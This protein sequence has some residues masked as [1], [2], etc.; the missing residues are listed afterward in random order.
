MLKQKSIDARGLGSHYGSEP[1]R[2]GKSRGALLNIKPTRENSL[3]HGTSSQ[4]CYVGVNIGA[5]T[6]KAVALRGASV[7]SGVK[8]HQGRP[9]E[10]LEEMLASKEFS[11]ADYFGVSGHRGHISEAAAI[12]RVLGEISCDFDA[13][14][15]L[16]GESFLVY[17]LANGRIMN[18]LSHNKCAAGSGEFF[19]QQ[20]SRMRLTTEEAI[21]RSFSGKVV[22]LASRCSVHC[23]SDITHKLNRNEACV[24]DILHTLHDSMA[25]KVVSLLEKGQ[26][27]LKRVLVIGGASQNA[28]LLSS[29][30]EKLLSTE[31]VVVPESLCFE[32]WGCA[33][34]TR[35][36]PRYNSPKISPQQSLDSFPPLHRQTDRV[37]VIAPLPRQPSPDGLLVL[38]LDAGSTTTK[39]ILLDPSTRGVVSSHYTRTRSDPVGATR[40]CLRAMAQ[41]AGNLRIGLVGTTGSARELVGAYLGTTYVYNEISAHAAGATHFDGDVDNIFEIGGQDSKYI[42]LRNGVP[43]DYAMNNACSA[44]TGSFLE[45]SAQGDLGITVSEIAEAALAAASPVQLKA[46]CAA[47][48]NSDIRIAFQQGQSRENI[49]A[50]LVYAIAANYLTKVKGPRVVGKK[51]FLQG[52]VA[53]NRA[54]G[55]AFA[56]SVDRTVVIP[57]NPELMGALGVA[58]MALT[59]CCGQFDAS[60]DL[61]TFASAEMASPG[62]FI[63]KAC[64]MHCSIDRFEVAGRRFPFGGRCSLY[65]HVWKRNTHV[66]AAPDL[67]GQRAE[68][69]FGK[70]DD[71]GEG[72]ANDR[73]RPT[74]GIPR[75]LLTHSL[76]PLYSIFFSSLGS[77]VVL[78]GLD[79]HGELKSNS[80]FCFPA[81]TAHGAILDLAKRGVDLVFL[82]HVKRMP[83][84]RSCRDSYLCPITQASP[85]FL[86][87]AFPDVRFLSPV[88]DF[89][90][91]YEYAPDL[92]VMIAREFGIGCEKVQQAWE[93]AKI[94]QMSAERA[95]L[96]L[97]QQ[98]LEHAL[99]DGKPT[100]I[101]A[102]RSYNAYAPE[103]SQSVGRKLSSM[104]V[105][106][107]P[108]DCLM[109]VE[110]GPFA[111]HFSNQV[112]NAMSLV[113]KHPNLFLV[114]I[115]N[116]SCT[117]DAFTHARVASEMG[118][119]P[120]LS[121]EIDS[122]T[123]DAG[124]Q[125]RLEAYLDI[126]HNYQGAPSVE[127]R[128]FSVCRVGA[129]NTV[130]RSQGDTISMQ[131]PSVRFYFP[132]F[133]EVHAQAMAMAFR[134][135][136]LHTGEIAPLDRSQLERGLRYTSGRECLPLPLCIGQ[137]LK[138]KE[139]RGP[140]EISGFYMLEGGAPCVLDAYL[141]YFKRFIVEQQLSDF[142]L[143][144]PTEEN[145]QSMIDRLTL[146]KHSALTLLVADL[147]VEIEHV[148]R[149]VGA[150]G[151]MGQLREEWHRFI[152]AAVSADRFHAELAGFIERIASLPRTRKPRACPRVIVIG[153]FFTRFSPFFMDGV[154]DRYS[155]HGIILKPVDMTDLLF[156]H[157]YY[158]VA[159]TAHEWRM[160]PGGLAVAKACS[161]ILRRDG[162]KYLRN[163]IAYK[164]E[165][166]IEKDYRRLFAKTGL[167]VAG[168][169]DA[170]SLFEKASDY[171]SPMIYGEIIPT[172]GRGLEA[173]AEGNDGIIIIGPFNCLP[174]RISE[175]ILKPV[176]VR[177]GMPV[178]TYESDGYAVSPS[179]LRQVDVHIQQVLEHAA[180][181]PT[182]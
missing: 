50:G 16:G 41:D 76:Y 49:I 97:G 2:P 56:Y 112:L 42:H 43:V 129:G 72:P 6:V 87:A 73:G 162:K 22:P 133:S 164:M 31:I 128:Q 9:L 100:I 47:F 11:G 53:L 48:I 69:I 134:W 105:T 68:L 149:V 155:E 35:D 140:D 157:T 46:T 158:P 124:I 163:W 115:S 15:S 159:E 111:W 25:D 66:V 59:R 10:V 176:S 107:I 120:Y 33:L 118:S 45:E 93:A 147:L 82:P 132:N 23:K 44:G 55:N 58:L 75:A 130:I 67:V 135:M 143:F 121:L 154:Q 169:N 174:F 79:P 103:S 61:L 99:S 145:G 38:G 131:D 136:G 60:T 54:V 78:S 18:V 101:L 94:A 119:K 74:I 57:P 142:F 14:A 64:Q 77:D 95:L 81:Q 109:P 125:T 70:T 26:R 156:Y 63:C 106:V 12:E 27:Q 20:I 148:L 116:F 171:V 179:V 146:A 172:I 152:A 181:I 3:S 91:G 138:I 84:H 126:V 89:T 1:C 36:E 165:R 19:V 167:L 92:E 86:A 178:L 83:Q 52:G 180:R 144:V 85:Y 108:A 177:D 90:C 170:A 160:K 104:G 114:C 21:E 98:A 110:E 168:P 39:A 37:Q 102:G 161:R 28:A 127:N 153:D 24:N 123:A 96:E 175:S 40:E 141:D 71:D 5:I 4:L 34:L 113:K 17:L 65:E 30:R 150:R 117:V 166:R 51:V 151:S 137:L 7:F 173:E 88:L 139:D 29:L 62:R 8:A 182:A 13:V 122:H 80:G 32:A